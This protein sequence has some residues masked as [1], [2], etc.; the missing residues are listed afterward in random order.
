MTVTV[1][2][3]LSALVMMLSVPA[4]VEVPPLPDVS[5][6]QIAA[7]IEDLSPEESVE[8][9]S[10]AASVQDIRVEDS[11]VDLETTETDGEDTVVALNSDI[12]FAFDSSDISDAA[13]ARIEEL[14]QEIPQGAAVSVGGHTD[15]IGDAAYNQ[16][17][18][19]ERAQ[20]V[21]T[22]LSA[23]RSDLALTVEGFGDTQP[24]EPNEVNGEDNPDG[25]AKNRRV[26]IRFEQ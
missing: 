6:Q 4:Q 5:P 21:A 10:I 8:D 23:A 9:L 11:V 2:P 13:R 15:S 26:E 17:L 25:R 7:S 22:V 19:G 12:L 3:V 1:V 14:A 16:R 18:S 24:I 20:A